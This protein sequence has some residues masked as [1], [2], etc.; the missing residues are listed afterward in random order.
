VLQYL[1]VEASLKTCD[2]L[3]IRVNHVRSIAT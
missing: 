2:F 1:G 3:D